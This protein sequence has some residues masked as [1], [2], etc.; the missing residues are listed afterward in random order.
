M[1]MLLIKSFLI[2]KVQDVIIAGATQDGR[3][4]CY[5]IY[6]IVNFK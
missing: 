6:I 3:I 5:T 2:G 4:D 1:K